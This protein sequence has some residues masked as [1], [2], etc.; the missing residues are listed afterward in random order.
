MHKEKHYIKNIR[1]QQKIKKRINVIIEVSLR[2]RENNPEYKQHICI[3][4]YSIY[5]HSEPSK[6][7]EVVQELADR[8]KQNEVRE[9]MKNT[10]DS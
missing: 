10:I 1:K 3:Y 9:A 2:M 4:I 8:M 6:K 7:S 5:I